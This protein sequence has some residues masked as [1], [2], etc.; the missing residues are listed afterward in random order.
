MSVPVSRGGRMLATVLQ[1]S[2]NGIVETVERH[3]EREQ[4]RDVE[5]LDRRLIVGQQRL[6]RGFGDSRRIVEV[7]RARPSLVEHQGP[8][9]PA[10]VGHGG[11]STISPIR[12]QVPIDKSNST[13]TFLCV[14][15]RSYPMRLSILFLAVLIVAGLVGFLFAAKVADD[16]LSFPV[17]VLSV[18]AVVTGFARGADRLSRD[19]A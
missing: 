10:V 4:R 7:D 5:L 11:N 16:L 3:G 12:P 14:P 15:K 13:I 19:V 1:Q 9:V 8:E 2:P 17:I 6:A 18:V